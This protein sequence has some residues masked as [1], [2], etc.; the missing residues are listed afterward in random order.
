MSTHCF[1]RLWDKYRVM[2]LN[3][4]FNNIP[5]DGEFYWWR[6]PEENHRPA[7]SHS[8]TLLYNVVSS[9]HRHERDSNSQWAKYLF[10]HATI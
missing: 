5:S 4:T 9:T 7:G 1:Y 10:I 2:V 3:A 6:K 8:E